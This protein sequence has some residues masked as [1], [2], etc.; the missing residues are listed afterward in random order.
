MTC[1]GEEDFFKIWYLDAMATRE[2]NIATNF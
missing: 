1:L 2:I